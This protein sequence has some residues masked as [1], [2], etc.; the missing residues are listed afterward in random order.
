MSR[1]A[2]S[3]PTGTSV[4]W[5]EYATLIAGLLFCAATW[6]LFVA[7]RGSFALAVSSPSEFAA[8][9]DQRTRL[10]GMLTLPLGIVTTGLTIVALLRS[11]DLGAR[12]SRLRLATALLMFIMLLLSLAVI[13]PIEHRIAAAAESGP[14]L[15][16]AELMR[17]GRWDT[18][19]T[20]VAGVIA[21]TL[22]LAHRAPVPMVAE[23]SARGLTA[24]HRTVLMLVGAA[25]LF[26][27]Y[28][29]FIASLALPY[30]G[31][32]L[33][34]GEGTL[35]T[36]LAVIRA[37]A[38]ISI[39]LGR[40]ADRWGRRR[41][42]IGSIVA[43]T[44]AT[45]AT[46]F[47]R[48]M[49]DFA[50]FQLV[51]TIFLATELS[52]A[53]V[54][55]AEEFPPGMRGFGQG[56]LGA[57][58]SFGAGLAAMLFPILQRTQFGWRGMYLIGVL[59]LFIV[60]YLQRN[61]PETQ[62]WTEAA[63]RGG[64]H[65][66][67]LDLLRRG[68]RGRLLIL[69]LISASTS[70]TGATAFSFAA[71]RATTTF[72]WNPSQVSSMIIGGGAVG[73]FAYF[74]LGRSSDTLGRRGIGALGLLSAGIAVSAFYQSEWLLPAFALMTVS[75]SGVII[76]VNSLTTELFPTE[77]RAT[78]KAWV[79]NSSIIGALLGLALIGALNSIAAGST[80]ITGLAVTTSL[81]SP[82]IF[83]LPETRHLDLEEVGP[84][85]R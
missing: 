82:A 40:L 56:V 73:F 24:R 55:I 79:T 60:A 54:V 36:A 12:R 21:A 84:A 27:G 77:L 78:A 66:R 74:V 4:P 59:P 58:A 41:L 8:A 6:A 52:L 68:F 9:L 10:A 30:I 81:L 23:V 63:E 48:G 28:D 76:A 16:S 2:A 34:A 61:L 13:E 39:F 19:R 22:V 26:E 17:L 20:G 29:R 67:L 25:T 50:L 38:L 32:D 65:G 49:L 18:L 45:A 7:G 75:E 46:G 51:A 31:R 43:Y 11:S 1:S 42:L 64:G 69:S 33:G 47:S 70:A 53:Q 3:A 57:F 5:A 80:V 71:Y 14:V 85:A 35:G 15:L 62:R 44:I 37:G 83:L 72:G